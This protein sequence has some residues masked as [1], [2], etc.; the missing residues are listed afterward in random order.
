MLWGTLD[1]RQRRGRQRGTNRHPSAAV[2]PQ[3][4]KTVIPQV[5]GHLRRQDV[6]LSIVAGAPLR[7][8]PTG[9]RTRPLCWAMPN[10][11]GQIGQGITV[12]TATPEVCGPCHEQAQAIIRRVGRRGLRR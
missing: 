10:T 5:R 11:P 4:L 6:G 1:D 3:V 7:M 9:W 2:K 8:W 12:W